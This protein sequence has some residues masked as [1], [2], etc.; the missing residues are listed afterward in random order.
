MT[1]DSSG[2]GT[3]LADIDKEEKLFSGAGSGSE[4]D[5]AYTTDCSAD[6]AAS[7]ACV[8][9]AGPCEISQCCYTECGDLDS[10][11]CRNADECAWE[12]PFRTCVR[13]R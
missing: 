8:T 3:S 11:V 6:C 2:D 7:S 13:G 10:A 1:G 5:D 9:S 4:S 12:P